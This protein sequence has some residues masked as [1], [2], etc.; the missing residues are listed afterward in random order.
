MIDKLMT[1]G[2]CVMIGSMLTSGLLVMTGGTV[3]SGCRVMTGTGMMV[4]GRDHVSLVDI[5]PFLIVPGLGAS[6]RVV[7]SLI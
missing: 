6:W 2:L 7:M 1:S 3:T 5:L 4:H